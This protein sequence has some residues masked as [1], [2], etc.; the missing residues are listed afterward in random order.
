MKALSI[1]NCRQIAKDKGGICLSAR[2]T[3]SKRKYKKT[4]QVKEQNNKKT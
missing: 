4:G 1:K 2:Y 3:N